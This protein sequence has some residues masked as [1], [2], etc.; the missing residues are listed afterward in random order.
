MKVSTRILSAA[1]AALS[2]VLLL[3]SCSSMGGFEDSISRVA[4]SA[5]PSVVHI[6]VSGVLDRAAAPSP[7]TPSHGD[8]TVTS[9][10]LMR[11]LGSGILISGD[12][13]IITNNHVVENAQSITVSFFDGTEQIAYVVG[14]DSVT[15]IAVIK[16]NGTGRALAAK[17]GDS[18]TLRVGEWVVAIGSPRGLDWT[19]TG[20]GG[21]CD[22]PHEHRD[23]PDRPRGLHPD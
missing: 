5:L 12:G 9:Q 16:V 19:V 21:Q 13:Y 18:D 15:D 6:D 14:T 23:R 3:S 1:A 22:A 8:P 11:A 10:P 17:I 7:S 2:V 4:Q 20:R